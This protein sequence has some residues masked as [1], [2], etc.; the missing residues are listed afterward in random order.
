MNFLREEVTVENSPKN[1]Q[2]GQY[3]V[4]EL[5]CSEKSL[6][7]TRSWLCIDFD[8]KTLYTI[9]IYIKSL[10]SYGYMHML[11]L[12]KSHAICAV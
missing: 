8:P 4:L 10:Y 3:E 12:V 11:K 7:K 2:L 1:L 6:E 5:Q 9:L